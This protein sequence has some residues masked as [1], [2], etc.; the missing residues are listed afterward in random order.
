MT[1]RIAYV[2][3]HSAN[4]LPIPLYSITSARQAITRT[5]QGNRDCGS[6]RGGQ[7]PQEAAIPA[8]LNKQS[9]DGREC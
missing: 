5:D 4:K 3:V 7:S 8:F 9:L 2:A 1:Y 6:N